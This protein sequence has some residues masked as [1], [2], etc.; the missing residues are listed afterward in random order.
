MFLCILKKAI[1]TEDWYMERRGK[2]FLFHT[3]NCMLV[4]ILYPITTH[5][6]YY[7]LQQNKQTGNKLIRYV[8]EYLRMCTCGLNSD[9]IDE[10]GYY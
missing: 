4:L 8:F 3:S 6:V 2:Q 7:C 10:L 1:S 9:L 5:I